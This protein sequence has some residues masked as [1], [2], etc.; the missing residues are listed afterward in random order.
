MKGTDLLLEAQIAL[1]DGSLVTTSLKPLLG[2][3]RLGQL[4]AS[5]IQR[6]YAKLSARYAPN[7]QLHAHRPCSPNR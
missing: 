7:D 5:H 2:C 6:A 3:V 4:T 1:R